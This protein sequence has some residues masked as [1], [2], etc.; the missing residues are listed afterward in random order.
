[1]DNSPETFHSRMPEYGLQI[2][3][4][5]HD[6]VL[7]HKLQ[8]RSMSKSQCLSP[9]RHSSKKAQYEVE[10]SSRRRSRSPRDNKQHNS[11]DQKTKAGGRSLSPKRESYR[12]QQISRKLT[13]EELE[14]KRKEMIENAKWREEERATNVHRHRKEEERERALEKLGR[15]DGKFIHHM[16]LESASTSS[17]ED[18]V[19]RN[20]H[21][22]QRTAAALEK[23]FMQR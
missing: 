23:N 16:K 19:K 8:Q 1:M 13:A 9:E 21:S 15:N 7:S 5:G 22:I 18:R 4:N 6:K 2:R 17:L 3:G 10:Q 11:R 12:R 14:K 20:I